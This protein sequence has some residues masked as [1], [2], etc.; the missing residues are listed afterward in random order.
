MGDRTKAKE[1]LALFIG[2]LIARDGARPEA[3]PGMSASASP[4]SRSR[5]AFRGQVKRYL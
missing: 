1:R 3:I 4:G 5:E 2:Q